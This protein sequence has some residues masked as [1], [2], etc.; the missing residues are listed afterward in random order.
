MV[1]SLL[2]LGPSGSEESVSIVAS[3][4]AKFPLAG[5]E[6]GGKSPR[7]EGREGRWEEED[8][9]STPKETPAALQGPSFILKCKRVPVSRESF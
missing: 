6:M 1:V 7:Q 3:K 4:L 9:E 2:L 8:G 5:P